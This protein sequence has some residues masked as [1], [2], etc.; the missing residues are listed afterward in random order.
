MITKHNSPFCLSNEF[1]LQDKKRNINTFHSCTSENFTSY[2]HFIVRLHIWN[3]ICEFR[4]IYAKYSVFIV[5]FLC[6]YFIEKIRWVTRTV[7]KVSSTILRKFLSWMRRNFV[8]VDGYCHF[9]SSTTFEI[10]IS[11]LL[12]YCFNFSLIKR[13][14]YQPHDVSEK[15]RTK[16]N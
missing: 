10:L 15:W 1:S 7:R 6:S 3:L 12:N 14:A 16:I 2:Y 5:N 8:G 11:I 13:K 4:K 9:V